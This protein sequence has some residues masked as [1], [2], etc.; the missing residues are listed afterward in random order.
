MRA[1]VEE[2][3]RIGVTKARDG[4]RERV[5]A[6]RVEGLGCEANDV[7]TTC[8]AREIDMPRSVTELALDRSHRLESKSALADSGRPGQSHEAVLPQELGHLRELAPRGR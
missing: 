5:C 1:P 2:E 4:A 3:H 8:R 6:P 7:G